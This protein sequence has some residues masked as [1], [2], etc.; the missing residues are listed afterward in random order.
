MVAGICGVWMILAQ[1][2]YGAGT[3][4]DAAA[5]TGQMSALPDQRNQAEEKQRELEEKLRDT[6]EVLAQAR[7]KQFQRK[8]LEA[9]ELYRKVVELHRDELEYSSAALTGMVECFQWLKGDSKAEKRYAELMGKYLSSPPPLDASDEL[10]SCRTAAGLL[11]AA[12]DVLFPSCTLARMP[13]KTPGVADAGWM[14][15]SSATP[16]DDDRSLTPRNPRTFFPS[17][18]TSFLCGAR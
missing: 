1:A 11:D 13:G 14:V 15:A 3:N 6:Q 5:G 16:P 9:I 2:G 12:S 17:R 7:A 10:S 8:P 4:A 18:R